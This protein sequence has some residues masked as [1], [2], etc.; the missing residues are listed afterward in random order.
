MGGRSGEREVSLRSG[1]NVS[2]S[3]RRQGFEHIFELDLSDDL[4]SQ[5]RNNQIGAVFIALHGKY[6]E[7]GCV[8][9]LLELANIPYTGSRVLASALAMDKV[10]AKRILSE[11]RDPDLELFGDRRDR[12]PRERSGAD[13]PRLPVPA[14]GKTGLRGVEP[15]RLNRE[16]GGQPRRDIESGARR[17]QKRFRRRIH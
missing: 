9:G 3:L 14:G 5:L 10:Q 6:G 7:D 13:R 2:D 8:Q 4:T 11:Q 15:R 16:S 17:V 1:R 12:Q